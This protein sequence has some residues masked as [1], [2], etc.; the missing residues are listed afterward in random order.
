MQPRHTTQR[1]L[2][3]TQVAYHFIV[4]LC[5]NVVIVFMHFCNQSVHP[6]LHYKY[7]RKFG[8]TGIYTLIYSYCNLIFQ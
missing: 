8:M 6:A 7:G 4:S 2:L 3:N 5:L 1:T